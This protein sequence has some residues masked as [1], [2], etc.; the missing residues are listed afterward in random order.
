LGTQTKTGGPLDEFLNVLLFVPFG[1]G[2]AEKLRERK[3]SR[4][5]TFCIALAA[6]SILSY[7]IEITQIYIPMR[8]SGWEDVFT[9][10]TGSVMGFLLFELLGSPVIRLLSQCEVSLRSWL[11]ARR[12]AVLLPIYFLAWFALSGVLQTRTRLSNWYAD[13]LLFLGNDAT[14]QNS[15]QGKVERLQISDRAISDSAALQL[16]S[17]QIS[18]DPVPWRVEYEFKNSSRFN[19]IHGF[20]PALSWLPTTPV[21]AATDALVLNGE[22]WVRSG[23]P[24]IELIGDFQKSN[25]FAIHIICNAAVPYIGTGQIISISRSPSFTDLTIKQDEANLVFW[26]RSPLSAKRAILAWY[27]PNVFTDSNPRDIVYSYDGANLSLFID[28]K[29]STRLY[30]L[31]PG[32]ALAKLLRKIRPSEL[33]GYNDIYCVLVFF[34]VGIILGIA[35][36][37]RIQSNAM[38][39]LSLALYSTAPALLLELILV[40]VSG[41]SFSVSNFLFSALLVVGGFLWIRSDEE[42]PDAVRAHQGA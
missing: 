28:G 32:A 38:I 42:L 23:S 24:V 2:L 35:A 37:R 11:T 9:N 14:G 6:G 13:C 25:Q 12:I 27:V 41:R 30:H 26:F 8:D 4:A 22:S 5:A 15:W 39:I 10:T 40:R 29:K 31:G 20:L 18:R 19:D 21:P 17:G 1:F 33:E 7:A 34:P 16:S 36:E 3:M